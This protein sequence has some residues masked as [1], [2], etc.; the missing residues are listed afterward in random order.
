M[1]RFEPQSPGLH[2][3]EGHEDQDLSIRGVVLFLASLVIAAAASFF[4]I[5]AFQWGLEQWEKRND[6][7]LTPMENQLQK[8]RGAPPQSQFGAA[9]G[10]YEGEGVKPPAD[11]VER[12]RAE[13]RM[14]NTFP[15]PRLQYDD[16]HDLNLFRN[17]ENEWLDSA[18]KDANGKIHIPVS[19]AM[20]LL[21]QRGLPAVKGPFLP[22]PPQ[23][24]PTN[25]SRESTHQSPLGKGM[26]GDVSH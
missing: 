26:N 18:G 14:R 13:Q 8:Q 2:V 5:M 6:A 10:K 22:P 12:E 3:K 24:V 20:D 16:T 23:A 17:S 7:Q 1:D 15:T 4:A 21:L 25:P 19:R 11:W 9:I